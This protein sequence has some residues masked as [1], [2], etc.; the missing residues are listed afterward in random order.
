MPL[1]SDKRTPP[2][3]GPALLQ[4]LALCGKCGRRM[5]VQY[6]ERRG[7]LYPDYICGAA[8]SR[9]GR[10]AMPAHFWP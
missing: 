5:Q 10:K 3:E 9:F 2:R 1:S 8:A 7:H 4:G 6:H